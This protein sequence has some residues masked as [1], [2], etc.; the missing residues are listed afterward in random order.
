[1]SMNSDKKKIVPPRSFVNSSKIRKTTNAVMIKET[2]NEKEIE[3]VQEIE[4]T[5]D[6]N[7]VKKRSMVQTDGEHKSTALLSK[8]TVPTATKPKQKTTTTKQKKPKTEYLVPPRI[9]NQGLMFWSAGTKSSKSFSGIDV[10]E[11]LLALPYYIQTG[12]KKKAIMLALEGY[13]FLEFRK[14]YDMDIKYIQYKT[15]SNV[16]EMI[17][18]K[19]VA[20]AL[21]SINAV[22]I[23]LVIS[24][25]ELFFQSD[26]KSED[27][28]KIVSLLCDAFKSNHLVVTSYL[29]MTDEGREKLSEASPK[30]VKFEEI[31]TPDP[32]DDY[33][34]WTKE[35]FKLIKKEVKE[36]VMFEPIHEIIVNC[37]FLRR[38][39]IEKD[40]ISVF[41]CLNFILRLTYITNI[42]SAK[43]YNNRNLPITI[44]FPHKNYKYKSPQISTKKSTIII[45]KALEGLVD[46][47]IYNPMIEYFYKSSKPVTVEVNEIYALYTTI[48]CA[49]INTKCKKYD[50]NNNSFDEEFYHDIMSGK[51]KIDNIDEFKEE[52]AEY[53][54]FPL[55]ENVNLKPLIETGF[56]DKELYK[57]YIGE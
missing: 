31:L 22:H 39:I 19:C 21:K 4:K 15:A 52:Y 45:W 44:E 54:E 8:T 40:T 10:E 2:S 38:Y 26:R 28:Y 34:N 17:Y 30:S 43:K 12:N 7:C 47:K 33:Y 37:Y 50:M 9:K 24:T 56:Y 35:L 57:I 25:M 46:E 42:K 18:D 51:Y 5:E 32:E 48:L 3:P 36:D 27:L 49:L 55:K 14:V 20:T 29:F 11:L 1:M 53:V 16:V 41:N 23:E 13:R 6:K